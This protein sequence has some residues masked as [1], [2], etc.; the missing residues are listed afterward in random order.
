VIENEPKKHYCYYRSED[1][2]HPMF[3][4]FLTSLPADTQKVLESQGFIGSLEDCFEG[5]S[6]K[7]MNYLLFRTPED[8]EINI[9]YFS[10]DYDTKLL[11]IN[12][13]LYV[14]IAVQKLNPDSNPNPMFVQRH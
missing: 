4:E 8:S 2:N 14:K 3:K 9:N 10:Q 1:E 12:D 7:N 11:T 6:L 13:Q 5:I